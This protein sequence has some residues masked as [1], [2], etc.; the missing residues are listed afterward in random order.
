MQIETE[1]NRAMA[2]AAIE[3]IPMQKR[4]AFLIASL[5]LQR[6]S[7]LR[8]DRNYFEDA[9]SNLVHTEITHTDFI[10]YAIANAEFKNTHEYFHIRNEIFYV[11]SLL[12]NV[13]LDVPINLITNKDTPYNQYSREDVIKHIICHEFAV[14]ERNKTV[15]AL[16]KMTIP[17]KERKFKEY[18]NKLTDI[19]FKEEATVAALN[20]IRPITQCKDPAVLQRYFNRRASLILKYTYEYLADDGIQKI[21]NDDPY[22][23]TKYLLATTSSILM[24]EL[25]FTGK[26]GLGIFDSHNNVTSNVM[27]MKFG[28]DDDE[29]TPNHT[30]AYLIPEGTNAIDDIESL[31]NN[32][33]R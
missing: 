2:F 13:E 15:S 18:L 22:N 8:D 19:D 28:L 20:V 14:N 3:Q 6:F 9:L 31:L 4:Q 33:K 7:V 26:E 12:E 17:L 23:I 30:P 10:A 27:S 25:K 32:L 24:E 5:L 1:R 21:I 29:H 16:M 11:D